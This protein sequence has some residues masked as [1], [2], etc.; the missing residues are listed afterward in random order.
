MDPWVCFV[1]RGDELGRLPVIP[2]REPGNVTRRAPSDVEDSLWRS[3]MEAGFLPPLRRTVPH[4]DG[5]VCPAANKVF[6]IGVPIHG[7]A[8]PVMSRNPQER[9]VWFPIIPALDG[10]TIR[11]RC[12]HDSITG[13]PSDISYG[14]AIPV[15][16]A[17]A[18]RDAPLPGC[19]PQIPHPH[20]GILASGK[21][22][23]R[24][25]RIECQPMD[26]A[27]MT[28]ESGK[29]ESCPVQIVDDNPTINRGCRED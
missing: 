8:W 26:L 4:L 28:I 18:R 14:I 23:G 3:Q 24:K 27:V 1:I 10:A 20:S 19:R 16:P 9:S 17:V 29:L 21:E 6:P 2:T 5:F 12:E 13:G 7:M 11:G 25:M 22:V 15:V